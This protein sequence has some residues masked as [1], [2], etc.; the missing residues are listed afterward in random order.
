MVR[1]VFRLIIETECFVVVVLVENKFTLSVF[2]QLV[3]V[4]QYTQPD[5]SRKWRIESYGWFTS[6]TVVEARMISGT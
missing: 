4:V 6:R 3:R 5:T 1:L 2:V